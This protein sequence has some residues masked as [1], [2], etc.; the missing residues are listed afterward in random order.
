MFTFDPNTVSASFE[1]FPKGEYEVVVGKPKPFLKQ[2]GEDK[3]DS[4][5]MGFSLTLQ[6]PSQFEGKRTNY[7]CYLQSEGGQAFAKQFLIAAY[8][9]G[10]GRAEEE[11]FDR[12]V[13]AVK[14]WD[15]DPNG[16]G[17]IGDGW[18]DVEGQR[19]IV[20]LDTQPNKNK[21]EEQMQQFTGFRSLSSGPLKAAA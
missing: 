11:R 21:P 6:V 7:R 3:H 17:D 16:E 9:Y 10:K 19:L 1:I 2:A 20:A 4:F 12:E 13:G 8:G 5:G 15:F 14:N 18:K